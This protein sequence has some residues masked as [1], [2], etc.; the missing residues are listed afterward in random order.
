M[1]TL[2]NVR[3]QLQSKVTTDPSY[4]VVV[5]G[6]EVAMISQNLRRPVGKIQDPDPNATT[7]ATMPSSSFMLEAKSQMRCMS[8]RD[9]MRHYE[10]ICRCLSVANMRWSPVKWSFKN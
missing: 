3:V 8:A 4:L 10:N 5:T 1:A 9:I 7:G 2:H 6:E